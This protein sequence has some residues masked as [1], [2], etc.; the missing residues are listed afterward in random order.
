MPYLTP[1]APLCA[2]RGS[3]QVVLNGTPIHEPSTLVGSTNSGLLAHSA[4]E[5][6]TR[7]RNCRGTLLRGTVSLGEAKSSICK[8]TAYQPVERVAAYQRV[9]CT[10]IEDNNNNHKDSRNTIVEYVSWAWEITMSHE[11]TVWQISC[12]W[13]LLHKELPK[14]RRS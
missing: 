4:L 3:C 13:M 8:A 1:S 2:I 12:G 9:H 5:L 6:N 7:T 14:K 10:I 11:V